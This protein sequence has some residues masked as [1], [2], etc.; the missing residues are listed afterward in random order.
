MA[1]HR[2]DWNVIIVGRWNR[3]IFTPAGIGRRLFKLDDLQQLMVAVPLDGVSPYQVKHPDLGVIVSTEE[4]RLRINLDKQ[5]Y[6]VL[7]SAMK[8]GINALQ[9]LPET[10]VTAAGFNVVFQSS[11]PVPQLAS[12]LQSSVDAKLGEF[13]HEIS[14]R[15]LNRTVPFRNGKLNI[16]L[17]GEGDNFRVSFNFHKDSSRSVELI[18]WLNLPIDEIE[19]TVIKLLQIFDLDVEEYADVT[20]SESST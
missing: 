2:A 16:T 18:E 3:S 17:I 19:K 5:E 6:S 7:E 4:G 13:Q 8:T 10:P 15:S 20:N 14:G 11:E 1:L 12:L 9:W